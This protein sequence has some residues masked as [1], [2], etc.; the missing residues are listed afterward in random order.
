MD[1]RVPLPTD[2]IYKFYALFGLLLFIFG[3]G[4]GIVQNKATNDFM[5]RS[6]IELE[7]LKSIEKPTSVENLKATVLERMIDVETSDKQT[8]KWSLA[9][10]SAAGILLMIYGFHRWHTQIQPAQDE[11]LQLQVEK[12]RREVA[13]LAGQPAAVPTSAAG[14]PSRI[15]QAAPTLTSA[16]AAT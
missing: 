13:G 10:I 3:I 15:D 1:N 7:S 11:L 4:A 14:L 8:F 2:N 6:Y 9:I 16:A 5:V 12:L